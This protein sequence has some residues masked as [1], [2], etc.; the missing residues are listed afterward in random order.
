MEVNFMSNTE[1]N[2][3]QGFTIRWFKVICNSCGWSWFESEQV[4]KSPYFYCPK[5]LSKIKNSDRKPNRVAKK[6]DIISLKKYFDQ[7]RLDSF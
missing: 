7:I 6:A 2:A 4:K 3:Q 1:L 5:C